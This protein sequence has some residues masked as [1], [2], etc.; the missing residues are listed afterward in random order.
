[1]TEIPP[2]FDTVILWLTL[3]MCILFAGG[4]PWFGHVSQMLDEIETRSGDPDRYPLATTGASA[5]SESWNAPAPSQ[6]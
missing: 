1:M 2:R 3:F 5:D 6:T 4:M